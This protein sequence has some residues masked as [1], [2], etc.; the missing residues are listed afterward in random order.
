MRSF[1]PFLAAC[2]VIPCLG[3][4]PASAAA[5]PTAAENA[6]KLAIKRDPHVRATEALQRGTE[7]HD[8]DKCDQAVIPLESAWGLEKNLTTA[9]L[10]GECEVKL[11]RWVPA[12][13]HLALVLQ[14][15]PDGPERTR[16]D[17]LFR[18]ARAQVGGVT[19]QSS[20]DAADVFAEN[21]IVGRTPLHSEVFVEPG[22][23]KM[24]LKKTSVGEV[25]QVVHVTKGG[26]ATVHLEPARTTAAD[27]RLAAPEARSRVPIFLFAGVALAAAGAGL[28]LRVIGGTQ[29][30]TAD[31]ALAK[32]TTPTTPSPCL[33]KENAT[34]CQTIKDAR[35]KHD[36]FI[37]GSTVLFVVG[38]AALAASI[39]C[40]LWPQASRV[41]SGG[42]RAVA[43]LP[44]VSPSTGG[45]LV[46]GTF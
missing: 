9:T 32:L 22:D 35:S 29:G 33:A 20:L 14:E 37:N 15:K 42:E 4:A 5:P 25:E 12:A 46:Q 38:G 31:D 24:S 27:D 19:V 36:G 28:G 41:S 43:I 10:L 16:L 39:T 17:A 21:Q 11:A 44:V 2:V 7:L 8:Q 34:D 30:K 6:A 1:F 3:V 45:L 23:V 40:A 18:Q 13:R 26:S